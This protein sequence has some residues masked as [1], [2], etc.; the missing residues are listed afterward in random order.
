MRDENKLEL[1]KPKPYEVVGIKFDVFGK[2]PKSWLSMENMDLAW[3][4]WILTAMT[5]Q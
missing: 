2:V 4:G 3:I 1:A 5:Y